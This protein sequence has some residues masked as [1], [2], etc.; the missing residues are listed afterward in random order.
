MPILVHLFG[1]A[2]SGDRR[3]HANAIVSCNLMP[4]TKNGE[5]SPELR[6]TDFGEVDLGAERKGG[7]IAEF[8]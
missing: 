7:E 4:S 2:L 3:L 5:F 8:A 6:Y 1:L